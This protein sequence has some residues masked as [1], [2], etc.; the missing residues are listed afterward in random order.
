[1]ENLTLGSLKIAKEAIAYVISILFRTQSKYRV[2]KCYSNQV[3][4]RAVVRSKLLEGPVL[5]DPENF[6]GARW[7][8][9]I[10]F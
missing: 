9:S 5:M 7:G 6:G 8:A 2:E 4:Y 1:M 10:D 3:M